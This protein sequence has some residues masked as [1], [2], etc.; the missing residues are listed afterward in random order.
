MLEENNILRSLSADEGKLIS[1][2]V[3]YLEIKKPETKS[4][5][6]SCDALKQ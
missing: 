4:G 5:Q 6:F 1:A 3:E 2:A